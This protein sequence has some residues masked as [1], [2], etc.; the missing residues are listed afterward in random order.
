[1]LASRQEEAAA[2]FVM[3]HFLSGGDAS[4]CLFRAHAHM[5]TCETGHIWIFGGVN[6]KKSASGKWRL[7]T[8][9]RRQNKLEIGE[10]VVNHPFKDEFLR[11]GG[12][13]VGCRADLRD[14]KATRLCERED[15]VRDVV[16][17][18]A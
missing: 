13:G 1:M 7:Q 15:G 6:G 11:S 10:K 2:F 8:C 17:T 4:F 18:A 5:R 12:A 9:R 16:Q 14:V 3:T